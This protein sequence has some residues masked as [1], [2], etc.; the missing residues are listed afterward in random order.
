[1]TWD[2]VQ[3][4]ALVARAGSF[5]DAAKSSRLSA[6]SIARRITALET[7]LEVKLFLR[8]TKGVLLTP[9]GTSL[10]AKTDTAT[11][12][13]ND[14]IDAAQRLKLTGWS[15]PIRI[16]STEPIIADLVAP[17][18][19]ELVQAHPELMLELN[20]SNDVVSLLS[21]EAE[22]ALRF[23]KPKGNSLKV[24][25]VAEFRLALFRSENYETPLSRARFIGYDD[26]YG[27]I[28]EIVW[29]REQGFSER[30]ILRSSSTS[31]L[32]QATR[33]AIGIALLPSFIAKRYPDLIEVPYVPAI[34]KRNL[35]MMTHPDVAKIRETKLVMQWL[36][37]A[38]RS[39]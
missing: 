21:H 14:L 4:F 20:V 1:M 9:A 36:A 23:A 18:V 34:A 15:S 2:D 38:F 5:T 10:R 32:V 7:D 11:T 31:A 33:S 37:T 30:M 35:W 16:T 17:R 29:M 8:G 25:K 19:H 6:V 39:A 24:R 3:L 12:G 13:M 22:I 26:T 28:P 27:A